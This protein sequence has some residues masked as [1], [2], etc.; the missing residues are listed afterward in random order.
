MKGVRTM[1]KNEVYNVAIVGAT[2]AV[3]Q[4]I[5]KILEDKNFPV[6]QLKLL[7]SS[8]SAGKKVMFQDQEITIEE[9]VQESFKN[10]DIALFSAGGSISKQLAPKA[11]RHVAVVVDNT[12][13]FRLTE[14]VPLI[15]P[16]VNAED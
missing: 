7:S 6:G 1:D 15:V 12:S 14:D 2:G 11:V 4:K 5:V 3:G 16:E 13:A 9:A 8:R 10:V